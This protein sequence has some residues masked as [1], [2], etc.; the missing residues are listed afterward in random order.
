[1]RIVTAKPLAF[2]LVGAVPCRAASGQAPQIGLRPYGSSVLA[3]AHSDA[4]G[5]T[6]VLLNG[7]ADTAVRDVAWRRLR[8]TTAAAGGAAP[9]GPPG[10][11]PR[12]ERSAV[13]AHVRRRC[14]RD[15]ERRR[16]RGACRIKRPAAQL[17]RPAV[18]AARWRRLTGAGRA[19]RLCTWR[20]TR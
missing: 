17:R 10:D 8:G 16:A 11:S 19:A 18:S 2:R 5:R 12:G 1:M 7:L 3:A 13:A 14:G 9:A 4:S 15:A 20:A 6:V